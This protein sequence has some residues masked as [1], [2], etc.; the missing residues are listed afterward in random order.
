MHSARC[1][2]YTV[3]ET[4]DRMCQACYV[5]NEGPSTGA[6]PKYEA[7][8]EHV[9]RASTSRGWQ[10]FG[11]PMPI[12]KTQLGRVWESDNL[13]SN[14]L[15]RYAKP[16]NFFGLRPGSG[17]LKKPPYSTEMIIARKKGKVPPH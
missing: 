1:L 8:R 7:S 12:S 9:W 2:S 16:H 10:A 11:E 13:G 3:G 15:A 14:S 5:K 17:L 4:N 6:L